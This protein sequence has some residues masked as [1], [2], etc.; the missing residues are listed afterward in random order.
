MCLALRV[1]FAT[2]LTIVVVCVS[3]RS[4]AV[5]G[6]AYVPPNERG[7]IV[8]VISGAS[9]PENYKPSAQRIAL[10]GYYVVL[11][12]GNDILAEDRKGGDRLMD[13]IQAAQR[14]P[15]ALPGKV[16]V[17]GYSKGGGAA[18]AYAARFSD[19]V[20][21]V[22]AYYPATSWISQ[23]SD[24]KSFVAKI[25]VRVLMFAGTADTYDNCC[26]IDTARTIAA[27]AKDLS[28][29]LQLVEYRGAKHGF[30]HPNLSQSGVS[31]VGYDRAAE[32]DAWARTVAVL[33]EYL[34]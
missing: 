26:T 8:I 24:M 30:D 27:T 7:R 2:I 31:G 12:D 29:P 9:G 11:L 4:Y 14:S 17:V 19:D 5:A 13:A 20:S 22:I 32:S 33:R 3:I 23:Y 15:N 16:A 10:L 1:A 34:N 25:G 28:V 18:L 6:T 21:V